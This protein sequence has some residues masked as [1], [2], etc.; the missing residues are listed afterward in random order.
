MDVVCGGYSKTKDATEEIQKICDEVKSL[1]EKKTNE[2]YEEFIAV[3]YRDQVVAGMNYL[4]KV[5]VGGSSYLHITVWKKLE[6]DGGMI[7][8]TGVE[9]GHTKDDPLEPF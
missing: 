2:I 1:V 6:C 7:Q 5:H 9:K 8:L 3:K 4:I